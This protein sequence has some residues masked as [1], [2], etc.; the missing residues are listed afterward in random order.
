MEALLNLRAWFKS[1]DHRRGWSKWSSNVGEFS[2]HCDQ[3]GEAFL[4]TF[5]PNVLHRSYV[6]KWIYH[7][8]RHLRKVPAC[9]PAY[10]MFFVIG[11][12]RAACN[13]FHQT[14]LAWR[15]PWSFQSKLWIPPL[16]LAGYFQMT[17]TGDWFWLRAPLLGHRCVETSS[18]VKHTLS[19]Q[20]SLNCF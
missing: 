18:I 5:Y 10:L 9:S 16:G 19:E 17:F 12:A 4:R 6:K 8:S 13:W 20:K 14:S 7:Q 11:L 2:S 1:R 3:K 15:L